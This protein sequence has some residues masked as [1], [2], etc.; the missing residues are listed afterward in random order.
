MTFWHEERA[1]FKEDKAVVKLLNDDDSFKKSVIIPTDYYP[2]SGEY[3]VFTYKNTKVVN[4]EKVLAVFD[5]VKYRIGCC[6]GNTQEVVSRLRELGYDA[7]PYVGWLF[8]G[9]TEFPIHHCWCVLDG[10]KILDLADDFTVML[11]GVN[12]E[13]FKDKRGDELRELAA[14]FQMAASK[15]PNRVRCQ[16]VGQATPFLLYVGCECEPENGRLIYRNLLQ[17]YPHHECERNCDASGM[18]ATQ[19]VMRDMGLM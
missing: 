2:L 8:T 17:R 3:E 9:V 1:G 12:G 16:P 19:R 11:S 4:D 18:N 15:V 6:Y 14:A 5:G 10:D 7:K 13:H